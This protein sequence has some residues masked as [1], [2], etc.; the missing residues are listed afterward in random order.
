[1]NYLTLDII[2]KHLNIDE[3]FH[4]DD[5]Y[6]EMLGNAVEK[7]VETALDDSLAAIAKTAVDG[8]LPVPLLVCMLQLLG[9]FYANRENVAFAS[10]SE[11][12]YTYQYI[13]DLYRN[14]DGT[15]SSGTSIYILVQEMLDKFK[16]QQSEI[17]KLKDHKLTGSNGVVITENEDDNATDV[18]LDEITGGEY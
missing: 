12:P 5:S 4:D 16:S 6:L 1:M 9:T 10:S 8:K 2:K 15:P 14:Y 7:A 11:V 3:D 18:G 13:I 17:D